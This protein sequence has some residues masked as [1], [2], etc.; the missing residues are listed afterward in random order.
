M[1]KAPPKACILAAL[2]FFKL[3]IYFVGKFLTIF[4]TD[5]LFLFLI[6]VLSQCL[7]FL[8]DGSPLI[9]VHILSMSYSIVIICFVVLS[10]IVFALI[11]ALIISV[12][13]S[14]FNFTKKLIFVQTLFE[15][16]VF[17]PVLIGRKFSDT[18]NRNS[19]SIILLVIIVSSHSTEQ[20]VEPHWIGF[21]N[22]SQSYDLIVSFFLF[23]QVLTPGINFR[24]EPSFLTP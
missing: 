3:S 19:T 23:Q 2:Y 17:L 12:L 10:F 14:H 1:G 24:I 11:T 22:A 18:P 15:C 20:N 13:T 7:S 8:I 21:P 5:F 9:N 6:L 4:L 16:L